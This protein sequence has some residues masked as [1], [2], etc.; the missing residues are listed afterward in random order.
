[1]RYLLPE[2]IPG[3]LDAGDPEYEDLAAV[4]AFAGLR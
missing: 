2:Q 4:L 1:M 3:F